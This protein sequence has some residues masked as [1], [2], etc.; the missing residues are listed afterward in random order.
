MSSTRRVLSVWF[1]PVVV[2][3]V[4]PA[5]GMAQIEGLYFARADPD[6]DEAQW[7]FVDRPASFCGWKAANPNDPGFWRAVILNS[8]ADRDVDLIIA[9]T[10]EGEVSTTRTPS[11]SRIQGVIRRGTRTGP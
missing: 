5:T 10:L 4:I 3:L 1:A 11:R 8:E 7:E 9:D 2:L 6:T